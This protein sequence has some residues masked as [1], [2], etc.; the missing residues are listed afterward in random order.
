SDKGA[1]RERER[2]KQRECKCILAVLRSVLCC[3]KCLRN[4]NLCPW[5]CVFC[6]YIY[7]FVGVHAFYLLCALCMWVPIISGCRIY[8]YMCVCVG[9]CACV[10]VCVLCVCV[11]VISGCRI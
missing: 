2:E 1:E 8:V 7:V 6:V 5:V 11:P 4:S 3:C 10:L 9:V